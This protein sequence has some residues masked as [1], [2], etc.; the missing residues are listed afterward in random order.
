MLKQARS[1]GER[2]VYVKWWKGELG[3]E[4]EPKAG[5]GRVRQQTARL[6]TS[7]HEDKM[8]VG[9]PW[10]AIAPDTGRIFFSFLGRVGCALWGGLY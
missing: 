5:V 3:E 9:V 10:A 2:L 4:T 8:V 6:S 1:I 7:R